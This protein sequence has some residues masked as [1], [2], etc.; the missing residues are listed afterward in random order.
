MGLLDKAKSAL[1]GRSGMVEKGIDRAVTEADK[2]TKGKYGDKLRS[3]A[4][5]IKERA[6]E[7]DDERAPG[8]ATGPADGHGT[9]GTTGGPGTTGT[10]GP[11]GTAPGDVPPR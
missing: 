4:E 1:K 7:L 8:T 5:Q 2:R 3:S 6:R 11:I 9:T 10:T